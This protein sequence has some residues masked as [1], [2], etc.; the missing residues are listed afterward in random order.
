[1]RDEA[2]KAHYPIKPV[3]QSI[4]ADAFWQYY[5]NNRWKFYDRTSTVNFKNDDIETWDLKAITNAVITNY[6]A[7]LSNVDSLKR[8]KIDIYD[9]IINKGTTE[10][11]AWRPT[12]YDF[13]GHRALGFFMSSEPD[14]SRAANRFTVNEDV[15]LKPYVDF[16]YWYRFF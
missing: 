10:C 8:T 3:L 15:Y 2:D 14:V 9:A 4:L 12:L 16:N 7:S 6:K 1:M 13:L 11:R 5:Q